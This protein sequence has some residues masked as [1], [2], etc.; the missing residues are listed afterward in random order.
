MPAQVSAQLA[1]VGPTGRAVWLEHNWDTQQRRI[2]RYQPRSGATLGMLLPPDPALPFTPNTCHSL[3]FDEITG[4]LC[5]GLF[6]GDVYVL[7]FV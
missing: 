7:D 3:V 2:M 6:N 5:L 1:Q 4:R